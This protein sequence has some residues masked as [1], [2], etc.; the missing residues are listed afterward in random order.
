MPISVADAASDSLMLGISAAQVPTAAPLMTKT[1][2]VA[3]RGVII[4]RPGC[5]QAV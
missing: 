3:R 1:M 2:N 5:G 4:G